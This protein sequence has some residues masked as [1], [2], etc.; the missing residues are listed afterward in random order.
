MRIFRSLDRPTLVLVFAVAFSVFLADGNKA[1]ALSAISARER[2]G[3]DNALI[4]RIVDY[5]Y[6]KN[7]TVQR[8]A[9]TLSGECYGS[10]KVN[11]DLLPWRDFQTFREWDGGGRGRV[12]NV[13]IDFPTVLKNVSGGITDVG[14]QNS[15][16]RSLIES[17][18]AGW[19]DSAYS[20]SWT[21]SRN[22]LSASER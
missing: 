10:N 15:N 9:C 1:I 13:G 20:Q 7:P 6:N 5:S 4:V 16:S 14:G 8:G 17:K 18:R 3:S 2:C 21:M 22:K 12:I 11:V 19:E